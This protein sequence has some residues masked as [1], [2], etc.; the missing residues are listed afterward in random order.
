MKKKIYFAI[1]IIM[2]ILFTALSASAFPEKTTLPLGL[3]GQTASNLPKALNCAVSDL[4]STGY[5]VTCDIS[6]NSGVVSV[7]FLTWTLNN[8]DYR[9]SANQDD[10][11]RDPAGRISGRKVSYRV[12]IS[13]HNNE[14]DVAYATYI[15]AYDA[16]GNTDR[17]KEIVHVASSDDYLPES[18]DE[19]QKDG[20]KQS[21]VRDGEK[22]ACDHG[23][24]TM[25]EPS[26]SPVTRQAAINWLNAQQGE[27]L[28][29]DCSNGVQCVDLVMYYYNYFGMAGYARGNGADYKNNVPPGWKAI[30]YYSGFVPEPGDVAVWNPGNGSDVSTVGHVAVVLSADQNRFMSMDQNWNGVIAAAQTSHSYNLFWGVVRPAFGSNP[31]GNL[32]LAEGGEGTVRVAGWAI[33]DDAPDQT[34][35]IHVYVGGPSA[36]DGGEGH[37]GYYANI[38]RTD[39]GKHGFD[40]TFRTDKR[41]SQPVYVY[42]INVGEGSNALLQD[43]PKTVS[44]N[45][46]SA[47]G[48][49]VKYQIS[50]NTI[51]FSKNN[52]SQ[53]AVYDSTCTDVFRNDPAITIV[54]VTDTIRTDEFADDL[55][56]YCRYVQ[57]MY[58]SKLDVSAV[59]TMSNMFRMAYSD[60]YGIHYTSL[61]K[62]HK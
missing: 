22:A 39:V 20:K 13:D 19:T 2:L 41:G 34:L 55:F 18:F 48:T 57:E 62:S 15:Y 16:V 12:N 53:E 6:D 36:E 51:S 59:M 50:G 49:N 52:P 3:S 10:L 46:A 7:E 23:C 54:K 26:S 14:T 56:S 11:T 58:L 8:G 60:D 35:Q 1:S 9:D 40:I 43:N 4:T 17:V 30:Q 45:G 33:D 44:I 29:Y 28:D 27:Y 24:K 25:C 38:D 42:G 32:D 5:T 37:S 47:C 61:Q 21:E 31:R